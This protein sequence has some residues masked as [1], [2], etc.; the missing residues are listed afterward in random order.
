MSGKVAPGIVKL[1]APVSTALL[2]VTAPVPVEVKVR[3]W[4]A[5][6]L[7][8]TFPNPIDVELRVSVGTGAFSCSVNVF[9][10]L[11]LLAVRMTG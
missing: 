11:S 5:G 8:I 10:T 7:R 6:E 4:V 1:D 3:D 2:I 9:D